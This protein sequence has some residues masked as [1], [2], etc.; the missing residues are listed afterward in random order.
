[1]KVLLAGGS[2][3]IGSALARALIADGQVVRR[4]VRRPV[5]RAGETE[6]HPDRRE[7]PPAALAGV[8]A[9]VCLSGAGVGDHR[10]TREY[11]NVIRASRVDTVAMLAAS[12]AS[13]GHRPAFVCASGIDYYGDTGDQVVDESAPNGSTFLAGVCADWEA[14]ADPAREA[15]A[16]VVHLRSGLVISRRGGAVARLRPIV[17]MGLGGR[18]GSG[19]QYQPWVS[20]SDE[21]AAIRFLLDSELA[22]PVNLAAP[23]PVRNA[24]FVA[25]LARRLHRRAVLPAPRFALRIVLGEFADDLLT[26]QRAVPARLTAAGFAFEHPTLADA[27]RDAFA[28]SGAGAQ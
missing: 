19:R 12:I 20:L 3:L 4:L 14:A 23:N 22:G 6:W 26:G 9:V 17:R 7:V 24:E 11:K 15:G 2:G 27:L 10:W 21:V 28:R 8:D 25:E 1:M 18:L 5:A 16:R 13:T